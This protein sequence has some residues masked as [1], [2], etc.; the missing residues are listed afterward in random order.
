MHH[1]W[2]WFLHLTAIVIG[3]FVPLLDYLILLDVEKVRSIIIYGEKAGDL[4]ENDA[5]ILAK[6]LE[7]SLA[8]I[9]LT[10]N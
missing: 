9:M 4:F 3:F 7:S 1:V 6:S 8:A 10:A 2:F 5:G